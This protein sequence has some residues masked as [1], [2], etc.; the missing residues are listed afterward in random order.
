MNNKY[1]LGLNFL[2]SDSSAC[3]FK[4]NQLI[5]ASEEERFTRVKHT[6]SFPINSIKFC[7]IE[8]NIDISQIDIVTINSNPFS[9][10]LKKIIFVLKNPYSIRIA[11]SSL[12]NSKKKINISKILSNLDD[13]KKFKGK[14]K[15]VD[16]HESHIASSLFFS[17]F[18]ESVNLSIDGFGD[19]VS[20]AYGVYKNDNLKI[21]NKIY[22]PH[23]LGIFYQSLTQFLG[24][25]SYGDE[26]KL[27]GLSSY[28]NP[29]YVDEIHKIIK[30]KESG[31]ELNLEYFLHHKKK[32]FELND[33]GQFKYKNLYSSKIIDLLGKERLPDEEISQRHLDIAKSVQ[34]VYEDILFYIINKIYDKYKVQNL[35]LSGGCAMNSLANGKIVHNSKF[36]NIYISPC[37]GDAGGSIGSASVI[38]NN[39]Y[40]KKINIENYS[41]LG[42]SYSNEY[43]S[44]IID[45]KKLKDKFEIKFLEYKDL[46]TQVVDGL[47][48]EKIIGWFQGRT[49]WGPRAL[50]CR[51]ILADPRNKNI[52]EIINKKIKRREN[53]R[54]FAPSILKEHVKDWFEEDASVPFMSEVKIIKKD[55]RNLIPGVT[56]IDG[57]GRLQ[58]VTKIQNQHYYNLINEFYKATSV[59]IILN[60]SFN[61]NEPIVNNPEEVIN[62]YERTNMDILVMGNWVISRK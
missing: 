23:S 16:H 38:I 1:I 57:S 35:T 6:S 34:V 58:T 3:L 29:K 26:Y 2:H 11:L 54:P 55:K 31:F 5:A 28:G 17:G 27:M 46:F 24:F 50:G 62:C 40:K 48:K 33:K 49:E 45:Q 53:F 43:I 18:S 25:K 4:D 9:S 41:Y 47:I 32:V 52:K 22:F 8:A 59:P 37:P 13:N 60:T 20:C 36:K 10:L 21:D 14:I 61:E 30:K 42:P 19:F 12:L 51:S 15:F 7:L 39:D 56:H 44:K